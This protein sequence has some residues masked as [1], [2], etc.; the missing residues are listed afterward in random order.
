MN[1]NEIAGLL[2]RPDLT[3]LLVDDGST[4]GTP[5]LFKA[6]R[7][8]HPARLRTLRIEENVGKG[9]AVRLGMLVAIE[10]DCTVVGYADADFATS[11]TELLRLLDRLLASQ[12]GV[13]FG[14]RLLEPSAGISRRGGRQFMGT[15]FAAM[16]RRL[17]GML[18]ADTQCG[19]KWFRAD[20]TLG[21][22]L[23][24]PFCSRWAF[25]VELFGRLRY[26]PIEPWTVQQFVEEP[27]VQWTEMPGSKLT[28]TAKVLALASLF[29][30]WLELRRLRQP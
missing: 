2:E 13:V 26:A 28:A 3:V 24:Q 18:I 30:V 17:T 21:R 14:S 4:D 19:A 20:L 12:A 7:S 10:A 15:T 22:V 11:A 1:S 29:S 27:L 25:D 8:D 9:E 5:E 6:L 23:R 16:A